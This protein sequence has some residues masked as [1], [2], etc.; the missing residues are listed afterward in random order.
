MKKHKNSFFIFKAYV[1]IAF[2]ECLDCKSKKDPFPPGP[3]D[4]IQSPI[5]FNTAACEIITQKV[6]EDFPTLFPE[7][8][9]EDLFKM[10]AAHLKYNIVLYHH[11]NLP[12]GDTLQ[13]K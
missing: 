5:E 10:V 2:A 11:Q 13:A 4:D 1:W 3:P 8:Y 12:P 6:M 9:Y 7:E